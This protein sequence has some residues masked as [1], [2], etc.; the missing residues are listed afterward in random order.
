MLNAS[1]RHRLGHRRPDRG[2]DD[3][4]RVLNASRRHR[5]GHCKMMMRRPPAWRA[6]RLSASQTWSR[7]AV[8][9][10]VIGRGRVLNASRRHRLGHQEPPH[11]RQD[12][13][14]HRVLNASRRHRLGHAIDVDVAGGRSM[15]STPLGVTDLVTR[16]SSTST[17]RTSASRAQRLSASQTWSLN[18]S[19]RSTG[20]DLVLNASRRHRLG[21]CLARTGAAGNTS[22]Q[23]LSASQTWSRQVGQQVL[24][25]VDL[26][27]NASRRHRL[28][29]G[30]RP[31]H[32][33]P[34]GCEGTFQGSR[35]RQET[36]IGIPR[37]STGSKFA[38]DQE[39]SD[40]IDS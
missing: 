10:A 15:C 17:S 28:G 35:D 2:P 16:D 34:K 37:R 29:H 33:A 21:H 36:G 22:A 6:Q 5:L 19:R 14:A 18:C 26:V 27:L 31:S 4:P 25:D 9:R 39:N 32:C 8:G 24:A 11:A 3:R 1:R 40:Y 13:L 23:R 20:N 30:P 38:N 12:R 7:I